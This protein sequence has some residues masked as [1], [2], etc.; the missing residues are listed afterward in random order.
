MEHLQV[1]VSISTFIKSQ[2]RLRIESFLQRIFFYY[3]S[4]IK[5]KLLN[6]V[7][8]V[9]LAMRLLM[10][11]MQIFHEWKDSNPS[12]LPIYKKLIA[13]GLRIWVY[14]YDDKIIDHMI[15]HSFNGNIIALF[16]SCFPQWGYRWKSSFPIHQIFFEWFGPADSWL[17]E[18]M[19]PWE[20]GSTWLYLCICMIKFG[21]V[22]IC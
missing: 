13:G 6:K 19:V 5:F 4:L 17:L 18:T 21:G 12:V 8:H 9:Y 16:A 7:K 20:T 22:W 10:C 14:R 2:K 1:R 11:S 15:L 3:H